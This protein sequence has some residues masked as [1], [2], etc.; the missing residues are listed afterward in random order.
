MNAKKKHLNVEK[1]RVEILINSLALNG[2]EQRNC[3]LCIFFYSVLVFNLVLFF[4]SILYKQ[5][6][7]T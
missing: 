1:K 6:R 3:F 5:I 2:F 7:A 4:I